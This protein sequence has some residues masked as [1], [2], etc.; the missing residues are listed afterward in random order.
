LLVLRLCWRRA[1]RWAL[2]ALA[3]LLP[4]LLAAPSQQMKGGWVVFYLCVLAW[5]LGLVILQLVGATVAEP[6]ARLVLAG[7][8]GL[9]TTAL[10]GLGASVA[11]VM[12]Q[13]VVWGSSALLALSSAMLTWRSIAAWARQ[14]ATLLSTAAPPS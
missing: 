2:V 5:L 7:V 9:G 11:G 1:V 8:L 6:G 10:L 14:L 4:L 3:V 13:P 12:S